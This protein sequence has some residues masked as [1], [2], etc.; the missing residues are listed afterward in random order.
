MLYCF[1]SWFTKVSDIV[2]NILC[3]EKYFIS[4]NSI[5]SCRRALFYFLIG[6]RVCREHG[7]EKNDKNITCIKGSLLVGSVIPFHT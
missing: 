2:H 5:V 3:S 1:S 4:D 7:Q 6:Q